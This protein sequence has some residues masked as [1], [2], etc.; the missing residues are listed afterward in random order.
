MVAIIYQFGLITK[1]LDTHM[2][3][4]RGPNTY[5]GVYP[6]RPQALDHIHRQRRTLSGTW[7]VGDLSPDYE[8][9]I[10]RVVSVVLVALTRALSADSSSELPRLC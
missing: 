1:D 10:L 3:P 7:Q 2:S 6:T 8:T 5:I 4:H 9:Q